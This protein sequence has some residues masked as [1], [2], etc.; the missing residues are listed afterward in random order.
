[1]YGPQ[2]YPGQP[3]Y[4][5]QGYPGQPMYGPQGYPYVVREPMQRYWK[6]NFS[7]FLLLFFNQIIRNLIIT[8]K[9]NLIDN[10]VQYSCHHEFLQK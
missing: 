9:I 6:K 10:K 5:P 3:M 8:K 7:F 1:M 2:G 4:G